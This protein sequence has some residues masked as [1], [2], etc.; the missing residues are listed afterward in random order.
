MPCAVCA[1]TSRPRFDGMSDDRATSREHLQRADAS[2]NAFRA[3]LRTDL[4]THVARGGSLPAS[5][6]TDLEKAMDD[7]ARAVTRAL[8][9][10]STEQ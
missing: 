9:T 1:P 2:I 8:S 10:L 5:V 4:R 3:Q 6:V 7:A